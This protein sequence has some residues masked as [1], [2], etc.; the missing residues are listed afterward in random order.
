MLVLEMMI[1]LALV[2]GGYVWWHLVRRKRAM[3]LFIRQSQKLCDELVTEAV[4]RLHWQEAHP[5][6]S[7]PV[8][9]VWGHGIMAFEYVIKEPLIAATED[10]LSATLTTLAQERD[11][12]SSDPRFSPFVITDFWQRDGMIHLDV[13]FVTNAATIEYVQDINR[14]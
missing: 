12:A 10:D 13:A 6:Q 4:R 3:R 14:V 5:V 2:V 1:G 8:A 11:I 9:D 7:A